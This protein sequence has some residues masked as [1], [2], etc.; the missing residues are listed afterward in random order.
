MTIKTQAFFLGY[1]QKEASSVHNFNKGVDNLVKVLSWAKRKIFRTAKTT[2]RTLDTPMMNY[3]LPV[4]AGVGTAGASYYYD[5]DP[6]KGLIRHALKGVG[7]GTTLSRPYWRTMKGK[8]PG[9][10]P[11]MGL[12]AGAGTGAALFKAPDIA[13]WTGD[14]KEQ[15]DRITANIE[16]ATHHASTGTG[17]LRALIGDIQEKDILGDVSALTKDIK[18][19][20]IVGHLSTLTKDIKDEDLIGSLGGLS[21]QIKSD[22]IKRNKASDDYSISELVEAA[23]KSFESTGE[24]HTSVAGLGKNVETGVTAVAAATDKFNATLTR[25]EANGIVPKEVIDALTTTAEHVKGTVSTSAGQIGGKAEEIKTAVTDY[26]TGLKES[27][28]DVRKK[29]PY[30][31]AALAVTGVGLYAIHQ[32]IGYRMAKAVRNDEDE[33][34]K[35][36]KALAENSS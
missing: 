1:G 9:V 15:I 18:D 36:K 24:L 31:F 10:G 13:R 17:D 25:L 3:G 26:F 16:E 27:G 12:I 35:S 29:L 22:I 19:K 34:E 11:E 32:Y 23:K 2:S 4:T 28:S 5:E 30:I 8:L 33:I 14:K 21:T 20:D 6:N 7:V